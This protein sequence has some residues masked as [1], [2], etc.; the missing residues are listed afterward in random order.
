[1]F[2]VFGCATALKPRASAGTALTE[3]PSVISGTLANGMSYRI[4]QNKRPE[5]RIFLRLVVKAGSILE[6]D[7]QRGLAHLVEHLAFVG[8]THFSGNELV[9][10]FESIGMGFGPDVNAYTTFDETVYMLEIPADDPKALE[11]SLTVLGDWASGITFEE[12]ALEKER[13]VVIEEWRLGR[14]V[15]GRQTDAM[16]PFLFPGS[17]YAKRLP[18]GDPD[19]IRTAS[20]ER[21]MDF[22]RRWYRPELMTVVIVGDASPALLENAVKTRLS[23]VP[24]SEIRTERPEYTVPLPKVKQTLVNTDPEAQYTI[25]R[26]GALF[27]A[28]HAQTQEDYREILAVNTAAALLTQRFQEIAQNDGPFLEAACYVTNIIRPVSAGFVAFLPKTGAFTPAFQSV[29]DE[30]DRFVRFGVTESE[31]ERQKADLLVNAREVWQNR[32]KTESSA[33]IG[34]LVRSVLT[35]APVLSPDDQYQLAVKTIDALTV[36]EVSA[37]IARYFADRGSRLMVTAPEDAELPSQTN[38]TR[39][40]KTYRSRTLAPYDDGLD[41]RPLFSP[42]LAGTPGTIV[43]ER[44]LSAGTGGT[45]TITEYTLSNGAKVI[46]CPTDF[47]EDTIVFNAVSPGGLSLVNDSDFPSASVANDYVEYAGLNGFT[48]AQITKKLAGTDVQVGPT[49]T[50]TAAG[51]EGSA[52]ARDVEALFQL[53]NLYFTA[54]LFTE[55]AWNRLIANWET[56]IDGQKK[57][58]TSVFS[59]E[60]RR[61]IYRDSIRYLLFSDEFIPALDKA[62]AER[63]Y[64]Q[65]YGEAGNFTFIFTGNLDP[66]AIK[67]LSAV[68]LAS[69]P[70]AAVKTQARETQPAFPEGKPEVLVKK[71]IEEQAMIVLYFGG[72][73]PQVEGDIYTE[74]DLTQGLTE[75]VELR[76]RETFREKIGA[77]YGVGVQVSQ[78]NYPSRKYSGEISFGCEPA[79]ARELAGLAVGELR[80]MRDE[81]PR[82]ADMTKIRESFT[83]RRE[84]ALKTNRFWQ[85]TLWRYTMRGDPAFRISNQ[86]AALAAM[87]PETM[88]RLLN[89]YF[90]LDNYV[91]GILLP[92]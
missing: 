1:L 12:T 31:L 44:T 92:E 36:E 15:S 7:D 55:S 60:F 50:E 66:E 84:T 75:L 90:N 46:L 80:A 52:A 58:P 62:K 17:R 14:G 59:N 2:A 65:F 70:L 63:F 86:A 73:N 29:L 19:I 57:N 27:P 25:T 91:S 40:W 35:G 41:D 10:Y 13:N 37:V 61:T 51:F 79:R 22:Y 47:K 64:R 38:I 78:G 9:S 42:E 81:L 30:T 28:V 67:R 33:L 4:L 85:N 8:T 39:T 11:T 77:A 49:L 74:Q 21:I 48:Q 56:Q 5:N 68:Y 82:E 43:A 32:D 20:R 18:I 6:D 24:A 23:L 83:R 45:P 34:A 76:L 53:V 69:L 16:M 3:N 88:R 26:L 54:P 87:T 72:V 89:R 71:G